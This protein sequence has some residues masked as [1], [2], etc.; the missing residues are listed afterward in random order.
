[1]V[2]ITVSIIICSFN[3]AEHLRLTLASMADVCIP[4][5][6]KAELIV[7]DNAST[8]DTAQVV[9]ECNLADVN[10]RYIYESRQGQCYARNTGL[11][12]ARGQIILFTDDD[13]RFPLHWLESMC[14]PIAYGSAKAVAGGI[15]MAPHHKRSWMRQHPRASSASGRF[16]SRTS[17]SS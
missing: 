5:T 9:K 13:V 11:A 2:P 4:E 8:D 15:T 1:M 12:E 3:R 16:R 6:M 10:V 14:R 7:V 17:A